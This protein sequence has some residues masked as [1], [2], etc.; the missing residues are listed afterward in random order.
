[1]NLKDWWSFYSGIISDFSFDPRLD[2]LSSLKL[3]SILSDKS[4]VAPLVRIKGKKAVVIGNGENLRSILGSIPVG[5]RIVADSALG[6]FLEAEP[7][8]D[9]I[10]TDLDGNIG[11]IMSCASQGSTVVI[12]S[13]GDNMR[14]VENLDLVAGG[15][16]VGTTQN[17]PLWN[18]FNF[19]GFT[20]GDRAAF[21]ADHFGADGIILA[22]FHFDRPNPEKLSD[23][24]VKKKKLKWARLLLEHLAGHRGSGFKEGDFIEI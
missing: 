11:K 19:G 14:E 20:D 12:H 10:V 16:F 23:P 6:A 22:G 7:C 3:S 5:L 18:I 8:P 4:T 17:I 13:H 9:I 15:T 24:A 2:Y 21:L 1:M